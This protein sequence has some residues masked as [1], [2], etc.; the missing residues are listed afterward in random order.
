MGWELF[1]EVFI[2]F[3]LYKQ[4]GTK[5]DQFLTP[6]PAQSNLH[7]DLFNFGNFPTPNDTRTA[8]SG[9][10]IIPAQYKNKK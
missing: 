7:H 8:C 6:S 2:R 5:L 1:P 3:L 4:I 10:K 9:R